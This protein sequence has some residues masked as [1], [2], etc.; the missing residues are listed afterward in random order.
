MKQAMREIHV[1]WKLSLFFE[2]IN[3]V[4]IQLT[5]RKQLHK[6]T[7]SRRMVKHSDIREI[8]NMLSEYFEH[9]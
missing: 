8:Q 6:L 9:L 5:K 4:L 7:E 2:K 3:N 1:A